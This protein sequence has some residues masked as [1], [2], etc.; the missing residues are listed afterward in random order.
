MKEKIKG[1]AWHGKP[2]FC[3]FANSYEIKEDGCWNWERSIRSKLPYGSIRLNGKHLVAHR[4]SWELSNGKI[5]YGIYVL[6]KCDNPS[7]VNPDHLF[8]GTQGD[9]NRDC[10]EKNRNFNKLKT[11]CINGHEFNKKNTHFYLKKDGK[12]QRKCRACSRDLNNA[13]YRNKTGVYRKD[14]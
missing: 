12:T 8:L 11:R 10:I 4:Y 13:A 5:P 1:G 9:N 6:H 2:L 3:R 7:C 14:K